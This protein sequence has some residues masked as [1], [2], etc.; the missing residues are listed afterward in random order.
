MPIPAPSADTIRRIA[1]S[2]GLDFDDS[3]VETYRALVEG[4]LG[5]F[6]A[7]DEMA[8]EATTIRYPRGRVVR[9][10]PED[11]PHGAW[12]VKARIDG[13][14][15]GKLAG[16]TIA[17]KDNVCL[18]DV[19]LAN[20]TSILEGYVPS[21]DAVIVERML[22]AGGTIVGKTVCE[23]YCFSGGS[24]TSATG[25]VRNPHAPDFSAGGSSSGS[26]VV[27]AT[28]EV[29]MA[30][31]CDQGG[32][33]RIPASYC[34]IYG[35]KQTHGL[36]PYTG[37]LGMDP[38]I[39]HVGPMTATVA[40]NALLLE[41]IAGADG[42][43]SRQYSPQVHAYTEA[44]GV[45]VEGLRIGVVSEGFGHE[46]SEPDVDAKVREAAQRLADLGAEVSEVSVP[47]HAMGAVFAVARI[48]AILQLMFH[49]E[50]LAL[51]RQDPVD[52][53]FILAQRA[54]KQRADE[55]A[56]NLKMLLLL[57]MYVEEASGFVYPAKAENQLRTLRKAYDRALEDYD[58][59][60]MPTTPMKATP[61]PPADA[62]VDLVVQRALESLT[63]TMP[64][65]NTH[66]PAM[67]IPC[68][69]SEG[70]PVGMMLVGRHYDEP[71]IY[72]AAHAFEESGDWRTF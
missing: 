71:T 62:P 24:H 18:A 53:A 47:L 8:E 33:I 23:M 13:A 58:L 39:D 38:T 63:N 41:V 65:D 60:L 68:A 26:G 54:W 11:N 4:N 29:D 30:I 35:M 50:G 37:V 49:A 66:H 12:Y 72:R 16:K 51:G 34:G 45:G 57:G 48:P 52:P 70:R 9:P 55:L 10:E 21:T 42:E 64:F 19:P 15:E 14:A 20:G 43:D 40:D 36:V 25:P 69:M 3:E 56:P 22:D 59:L 1:E 2:L 5:A 28:G 61:I 17:V 67:S 32:S 44:L 46:T 7:L 31:G 27:V 6:V